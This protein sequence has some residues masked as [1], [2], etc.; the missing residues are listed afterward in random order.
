VTK[1]TWYRQH[2]EEDYS[3][4]LH[5]QSVV[6]PTYNQKLQP[7]VRAPAVFASAVAAVPSRQSSLVAASPAEGIVEERGSAVL[8]WDAASDSNVE[9]A[10]AAIDD[11]F[12]LEVIFTVLQTGVYR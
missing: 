1:F 8:S 3:N 4:C 2:A 7:V 5:L 11:V 6:P 12:L 9:K 10:V